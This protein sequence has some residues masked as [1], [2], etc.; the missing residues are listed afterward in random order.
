MHESSPFPT[1]DAL[2]VT[3]W[4]GVEDVVEFII[5]VAYV[6]TF[7][8]DTFVILNLLATVVMVCGL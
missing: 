5:Q 1:K 4:K 6:G 2:G 3:A 8:W 7:G